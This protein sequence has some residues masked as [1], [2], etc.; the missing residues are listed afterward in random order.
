MNLGALSTVQ[1]WHMPHGRVPIA[2]P[3]DSIVIKKGLETVRGGLNLQKPMEKLLLP[4][5]VNGR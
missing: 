4:R 3:I 2:Q 1:G 5:V